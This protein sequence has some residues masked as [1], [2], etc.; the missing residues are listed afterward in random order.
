MKLK[1]NPDEA[2]PPEVR[3]EEGF[4]NENPEVGKVA[5]GADDAK[6]NPVD[7]ESSLEAG[8][9]KVREADAGGEKENGDD[10]D[11]LEVGRGEAGG[12]ADSNENPDDT[13][14]RALSESDT[15]S[16]GLG[17][18]ESW[19]EE[20]HVPPGMVLEGVL[21]EARSLAFLTLCFGEVEP[22]ISSSALNETAAGVGVGANESTCSQDLSTEDALNLAKTTSRSNSVAC[23]FR[24]AS[25]GGGPTV[26][27]V[28]KSR[29]L[30]NLYLLQI[31]QIC[32]AT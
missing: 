3:E 9:E 7:E 20:V 8:E 23:P 17:E 24:F 22:W 31:F 10:E 5:M 29:S 28:Q 32:S 2:E 13:W 4:E 6:E 25:S 11:K 15:G 19:A 16:V 26:F 14:I 30:G 21:G 27:G 12:V 18:T 1:E